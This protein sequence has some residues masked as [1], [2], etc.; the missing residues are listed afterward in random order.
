MTLKKEYNEFKPYIFF[1]I[2]ELILIALTI[3]V[4]NLISYL[5]EKS[6]QNITLVGL[7]ETVS[8]IAIF[9]MFLI[10]TAVALFGLVRKTYGEIIKGNKK[11]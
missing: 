8:Q 9:I 2:K 7:L 6:L 5:I 4:I 11:K 10:H 3:G 1:L